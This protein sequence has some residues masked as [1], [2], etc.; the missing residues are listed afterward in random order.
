[1]QAPSLL[2]LLLASAISGAG[3]P[4]E[5]V[6][7]GRQIYFNGL[8]AAGVRI[9]DSDAAS[10]LPGTAAPCAR[11]HGATGREGVAEGGLAP[12]DISWAALT[13]PYEVTAPSGRKRLPYTDARLRRA[14]SMGLDSAGNPLHTSMPRYEMPYQGMQDL[15]A[16]LKVLGDAPT[17]GLGAAAIR[18]RVLPPPGPAGQAFQSAIQAYAAEVNRQQ[19]IFGR[20]LE[21]RTG[22]DDDVLCA[23]ADTFG[24]FW[25]PEVPLLAASPLLTP[26][27]AQPFVFYLHAGLQGEVEALARHAAGKRAAV[28]YSPEPLF[29]DLAGIL[30]RDWQGPPVRQVLLQ[31]EDSLVRDRPEVL[32]VLAPGWDAGVLRR[33]PDWRPVVYVPGSLASDAL[34]AFPA[35]FAFPFLPSDRTAEATREYRALSAAHALPDRY[36]ALQSRALSAIAVLV[37]ALRDAG[38]D[39]NPRSLAAALEKLRAYP[40]GYTP[41][42]TFT[43]TR[44]IGSTVMHLARFDPQTGDWKPLN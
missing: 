43:S 40:P 3:A 30:A 7:R 19:G 38:R 20:R 2:A 6:E 34:F 1:M 36:T 42:V 5:D 25:Q 13:K 15:I 16:W 24:S 17:P 39:V 33:H 11:C 18:I 4:A 10:R 41:P 35:I 28:L 21:L 9:G 32:F 26:D 31:D 14:I 37:R 44:H 8:A 29:S 23:I 27:T 22:T 12:P